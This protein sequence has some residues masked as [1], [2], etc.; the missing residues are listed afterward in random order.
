MFQSGN[1]KDYTSRQVVAIDSQYRVCGGL[2]YRDYAELKSNRSTRR[3]KVSEWQYNMRYLFFE[4]LY[5][6]PTC[7]IHFLW[8]WA[9]HKF[10][11]K[12]NLA[13]I[14]HQMLELSSLHRHPSSVAFSPTGHELDDPVRRYRSYYVV[15]AS[16]RYR[17]V[18]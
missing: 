10:S 5:D 2:R 13:R 7:A 17:L 3:E 12:K 11:N 16:G 6:N 8:F 1:T 15:K 14:G 4:K 18:V 9:W